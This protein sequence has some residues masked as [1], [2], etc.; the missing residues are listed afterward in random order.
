MP[1][2]AK[3]SIIIPIY[4]AE[5]YLEKC[6]ESITAQT[7]QDIEIICVNDGSKDGSLKILEEFAARFSTGERFKIINKENTGYGHSM[8]I[9][10]LVAKGEY[11]G[12]VESDDFIELKM[13][14]DLY[15]LAVKDAADMVKSDWYEYWS[16]SQKSVKAGKIAK[17]RTLK[18]CQAKD[19]P[20]ILK[21]RPTIWSAIYRREFLAKNNIKFLETPGASYQDTSFA[22]KVAALAEKI[23]F[24]DK[25]Y[26]YYRQD[27][28]GSSMNHGAKVY[29]I[30]GE[31]EEISAFLDSQPQL[32]ASLNSY[33]LIMQYRAYMWN[34]SRINKDLRGEFAERFSLEF[35]K[36]FEKGELTKEFF[37]KCPEREVMSLINNPQKFLSGFERGL[38]RTKLSDLRR[39]LISVKIN[40]SRISVSIF[41]KQILKTG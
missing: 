29:Y 1:D 17:A 35:K 37:K 18:I 22:F 30:C 6:L 24:S 23:V 15:A 41:G 20:S 3:I 27:N 34:L 19:D 36:Y 28:L 38:L 2:P 21:I 12:I 13:Y 9:G 32:K 5:Q 7:L 11:I 10:I 26:Y 14:E 16:D 8:N 4:N 25:A 31:Y 40:S 39:K 33:K